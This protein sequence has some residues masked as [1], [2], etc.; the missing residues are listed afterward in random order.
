MAGEQLP[1]PNEIARLNDEFRK[2]GPNE[3]WVATQGA[4]A[5]A[6]F[7]GLVQAVRDYDDFHPDIDPYG[8][9]DMGRIVWQNE[10]TYF[11]IDYYD[12][13][14]LYWCDPLSAECRR[15]LTIL[16]ASEY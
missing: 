14:L 12:Q 10:K 15:V 6:D 5:L 7:P 3:N 9:H 8:E 2:A 13:Q 4:L 11:K 1:S 16:L